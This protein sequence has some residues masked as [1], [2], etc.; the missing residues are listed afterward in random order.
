[1]R[2][3]TVVDN[4]VNSNLNYA[5]IIL[6]VALLALPE[7]AMAQAA[8]NPIQSFLDGIIGFLNSGV[9]RS[10]AILAVF[11]MGIAAYLGK[12]SWE[13]AMKIGGGIILTFGGATLVDQFSGYVA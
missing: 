4:K 11:G 3:K 13:L 2:T 7:L 5:A 12:I 10:M 9:M 1:M 8:G 6:T